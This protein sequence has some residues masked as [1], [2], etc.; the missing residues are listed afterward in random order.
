MKTL[1]QRAVAPVTVTTPSDF[2]SG[3]EDIIDSLFQEGD[4]LG[5]LGDDEAFP[6]VDVTE[7]ITK[8]VVRGW[9]HDFFQSSFF[10]GFWFELAHHFFSDIIG[11]I[12]A[13]VVIGDRV[14]IFT[15]QESGARRVDL[16]LGVERRENFIF[17]HFGFWFS[18]EVGFADDWFTVGGESVFLG[19]VSIDWS[20]FV[21]HFDR[22]C[23]HLHEVSRMEFFH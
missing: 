6:T 11:H 4:F 17:E 20:C 22:L 5:S 1:L 23:G 13:W 3:L 10:G 15:S 8:E 21:L 19:E 12:W 18:S 14:V 9:G 7:S 16:V 2:T